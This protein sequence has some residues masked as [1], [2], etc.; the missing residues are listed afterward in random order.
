M[1]NGLGIDQEL[2]AARNR[3]H[4]DGL[5]YLMASPDPHLDRKVPHKMASYVT[6]SGEV[7]GLTSLIDFLARPPPLSTPSSPLPCSMMDK[8]TQ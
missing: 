4:K 3:M 8:A 7:T 1:I 6:C 5:S 2:K